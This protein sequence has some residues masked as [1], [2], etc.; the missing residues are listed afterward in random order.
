MLLPISTVILKL[1]SKTYFKFSLN[2]FKHLCL[3]VIVTASHSS[4]WGCRHV[5]PLHLRLPTASFAL[6]ALLCVGCLS[7]YDAQTLVTH[8]A[9][10]LGL[11]RV[12]STLQPSSLDIMQ[13][14]LSRNTGRELETRWNK[15]D[16]T[17]TQSGI[18][19]RQKGLMNLVAR[20]LEDTISKV[21]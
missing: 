11:S 13:N 2:K 1:L 16:H 19:A 17:P 7:H 15:Q 10:E 20:R 14:T 4:S 9:S 8:P 6:G 5:S 12:H 18:S 21:A 3:T